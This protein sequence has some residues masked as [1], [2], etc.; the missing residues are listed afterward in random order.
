M[1]RILSLFCGCFLVFSEAGAQSDLKFT[2]EEAPEWSALFTRTKGWFGG[3]GIYAIPFN[4]S[5]SGLSAS[6]KTMF[7]FSDSMVGEITA[8][9]MAPGA[10]MVH[11]SFAI[12]RGQ[13]PVGDSL[14]FYWDKHPNGKAETVFIPKTPKTGPTDYY[15]LGDGFFNTA[16][17]RMFI[18]G[19]RVKQVSDGTFGFEEV[20]NTLLK[21][22][23]SAI[24][25][26]EKQEGS[27]KSSW[28]DQKDTPFFISKETGD[29]GSFGAGIYVNTKVAGA[30]A[31]DGYVYV[32]GVRG[33]AK[34]M[35]VARVKPEDF[36]R[37]DRWR[38]WDG[39]TWQTDMMKSAPVTDKVSN[40]LSVSALP[41]GRYALVF[42]EGGMG[43]H[44]A[45]RI[46]DTPVG[47]F[48]PIIRLY[49][50]SPALTKKS[51]FVYNAKA[52]PHLSAPGELLISYNVNS[53]DFLKDLADD[54]QLYRPRFIRVR[55]KDQAE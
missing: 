10:V 48:G 47:P 4:G 30:P 28:Y 32:Y 1:K 34:K 35:L 15:W 18:F 54:P 45:M 23:P 50:C 6:A 11:N 51:Y 21:I 17:N 24:G 22:D 41:D 55:F 16:L 38:F 40:E 53:F 25:A 19:Y 20:G 43:R 49:D 44:V 7:I 31:P 39:N 36:E 42:Q 46:G 12:M 52:Y 3:D 37:Y 13:K 26:V 9:K 27:F 2:V 5:E 29:M 14:Q 33:Q 8:G